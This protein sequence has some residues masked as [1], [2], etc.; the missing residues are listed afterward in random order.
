MVF[1]GLP[2]PQRKPRRSAS[3][4]N[5]TALKK[6]FTTPDTFGLTEDQRQGL[7]RKVADQRRALH[8]QVL[9]SNGDQWKELQIQL[10]QSKAR[11]NAGLALALDC[12]LMDQVLSKSL[13]AVRRSQSVGSTLQLRRR[14]QS[15]P[16]LEELQDTPLVRLQSISQR[17]CL[18]TRDVLQKLTEMANDLEEPQ[19]RTGR[20]RFDLRRRRSGVPLET[21]ASDQE[22]SPSGARKFD[23]RKQFSRMTVG[24]TS[25]EDR[26]SVRQ[27]FSAATSSNPNTDPHPS[28][29]VLGR[30]F[31][32]IMSSLKDD[33]LQR[34]RRGSFNDFPAECDDEVD[35]IP[36]SDVNE[37][38]AE[39]SIPR[40]RWKRIVKT[41]A[42]LKR[43][44][45]SSNQLN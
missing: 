21:P 44:N 1:I 11:T 43:I 25:S 9:H 45:R 41:R 6:D 34:D 2:G 5:S 18:V 38:T 42:S 29:K 16:S 7:M 32:G 26:K 40:G 30:R 33:S 12:H 31:S 36:T 10:R 27:R 37:T 15:L 19:E 39:A 24:E 4:P 23:L 35:Q 3:L 20:W 28:S 17:K 22:G 8:Q 14:T 13:P